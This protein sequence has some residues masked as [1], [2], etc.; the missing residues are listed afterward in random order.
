MAEKGLSAS[1]SASLNG[2]STSLLPYPLH[3]IARASFALAAAHTWHVGKFAT[4][5]DESVD[6]QGGAYLLLYDI[7]DFG[8]GEP[9]GG[10]VEWIVG[11]GEA[12]AEVLVGGFLYLVA[13]VPEHYLL[14]LC[15]VEPAATTVA[16]ELQRLG[17][18]LMVVGHTTCVDGRREFDADETTV[19]G[20]VG[21]DVGHVARG[22]ERRLARQFFDVRAI[23]SFRLYRGQLDNVLQKALLHTRRYLVELVEVDE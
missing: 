10:R 17:E 7:E 18:E 1:L 12:E 2:L 8:G 19:A 3:K 11:D 9:L 23:R 6:L 13:A 15:L 16:Q 22:Y 5:G 20:R 4:E 21:E 14:G